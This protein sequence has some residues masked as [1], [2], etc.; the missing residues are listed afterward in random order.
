MMC[1]ATLS[2]ISRSTS[3]SLIVLSINLSCEFGHMLAFACTHEQPTKLNWNANLFVGA[4]NCQTATDLLFVEDPAK[5]SLIALVESFRSQLYGALK[6]SMI[7]EAIIAGLPRQSN[8][9]M[10]TKWN[11]KTYF[12][13][14]FCCVWNKKGAVRRLCDLMN[15]TSQCNIVQAWHQLDSHWHFILYFPPRTKRPTPISTDI[16]T[17]REININ[18]SVWLD[19]PVF[20]RQNQV[21]LVEWSSPQRFN[22]GE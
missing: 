15:E 21:F 18:S 19:M 22:Y 6:E 2:I 8:L 9:H 10:P 13:A 17:K 7:A 11:G 20:L 14:W 5:C 3:K 16:E 4:Q 12:C 1:S